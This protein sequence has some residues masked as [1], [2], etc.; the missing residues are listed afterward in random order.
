MMVKSFLSVL[1]LSSDDVRDVQTT[2]LL[3]DEATEEKG[4]RARMVRNKFSLCK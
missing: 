3:K 1:I 4:D 2:R